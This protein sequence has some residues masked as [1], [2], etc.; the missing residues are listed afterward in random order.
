MRLMLP[1]VLAV[2]GS[3]LMFFKGIEGLLVYCSQ[4]GLA[5]KL[6]EANHPRQFIFRR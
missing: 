1:F 3:E 2:M 6:E 5:T 4:E